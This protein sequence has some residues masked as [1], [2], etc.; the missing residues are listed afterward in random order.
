VQADELVLQLTH[1]GFESGGF[2]QSCVCVCVCVCVSG[3]RPCMHVSG[4]VCTYMCAYL[5]MYVCVHI[6]VYVCM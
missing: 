4:W 2:L 6:C 5:R 3:M 1:H